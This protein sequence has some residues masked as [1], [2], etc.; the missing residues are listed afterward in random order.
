M[1]RFVRTKR[2]AR[3]SMIEL[4]VINNN[5]IEP[6]SLL[7]RALAGEPRVSVGF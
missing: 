7:V 2:G 1:G 6:D 3:D 5:D 4:L